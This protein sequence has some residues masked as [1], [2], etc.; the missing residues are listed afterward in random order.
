[1]QRLNSNLKHAKLSLKPKIYSNLYL[2]VY[3]TLNAH[4]TESFRKSIYL[5]LYVYV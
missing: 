3:K 4:R 5:Y 2:A 1:M